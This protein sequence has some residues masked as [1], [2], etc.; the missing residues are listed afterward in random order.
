MQRLLEQ[1]Q[2]TIQCSHLKSWQP[3]LA[4]LP[5]NLDDVIFLSESKP[6]SDIL[7]VS[8]DHDLPYILKLLLQVIILSLGQ[9]T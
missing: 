3:R 6:V 5:T 4:W 8:L 7:L 9:E 2:F 1:R